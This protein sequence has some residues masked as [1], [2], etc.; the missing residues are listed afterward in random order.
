MVEVISLPFFECVLSAGNCAI[1]RW[2]RIIIL[3]LYVF[4]DTIIDG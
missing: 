1:L 3:T 4:N 2:A